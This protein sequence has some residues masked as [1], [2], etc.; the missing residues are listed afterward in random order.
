[1]VD[2]YTPRGTQHPIQNYPWRQP[3]AL[4]EPVKEYIRGKSVCDIGCGAGDILIEMEKYASSICGVEYDLNIKSALD[5]RR[6]K[7]GFIKWG[8][9]LDIDFPICEVYYIWI[10]SDKKLNHA[11]VDKMPDGALLLDAT[12][13]LDLFDDHK[14]LELVESFFYEFDERRHEGDDENHVKGAPFPRVGT[15]RIRVFRKVA[16]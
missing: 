2:H 15:N 13:R 6:I 12:T 5:N 7:R 16:K 4:V 11:I 9:V 1:M 14:D 10:S 3:L 8:S